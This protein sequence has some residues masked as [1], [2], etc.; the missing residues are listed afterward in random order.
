MFTLQ[1]IKKWVG[2]FDEV[3]INLFFLQRK[4]FLH[5]SLN[6]VDVTTTWD[7]TDCFLLQFGGGVV[8]WFH[9]GT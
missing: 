6:F 1:F 8:Y 4:I 5:A 7:L 2:L 3:I 9:K